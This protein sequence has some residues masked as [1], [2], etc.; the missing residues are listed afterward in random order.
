MWE[1]GS[2]D[3]FTDCS[4]FY[5]VLFN[6]VF[7]SN[8]ITAWLPF[9]CWLQDHP[10]LLSYISHRARSLNIFKN[11][12]QGKMKSARIRAWEFIGH[13]FLIDDAQCFDNPGISKN[14]YASYSLQYEQRHTTSSCAVIAGLWEVSILNTGS[15]LSHTIYLYLE[16]RPHALGVIPGLL[17]MLFPSP[18]NSDHPQKGAGFT[19]WSR[20]E[21]GPLSCTPPTP[22]FRLRTAIAGFACSLIN[23]KWF[24]TTYRLSVPHT[25]RDENVSYSDVAFEIV[26][27]R[28]M[29]IL[30]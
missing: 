11:T 13:C 15:L 6:A 28:L 18:C 3:Y 20:W 25:R 5:L 17:F 21:Q 8:S 1:S 9:L 23:K 22:Q 27:T 26:V 24:K 29:W 4:M 14:L 12:S 16:M 2:W 10:K 19:L 30:I 7:L